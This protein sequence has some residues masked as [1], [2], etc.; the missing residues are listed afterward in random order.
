MY[1]SG[2]RVHWY[3]RVDAVEMLTAISDR[4]D[5]KLLRHSVARSRHTLPSLVDFQQ[6]A[7]A[8]NILDL[9]ASSCPRGGAAGMMFLSSE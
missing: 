1:N 7:I 6:A 4:C 9:Q 5:Q 2:L 8:D 3:S